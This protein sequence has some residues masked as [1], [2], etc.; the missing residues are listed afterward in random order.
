MAEW[1]VARPTGRCANCGR[2]LA[3]GEVFHAVLVERA[4]ALERLDYDA[5][6]WGGPPADA[7]CFWRSRVPERRQKQKVVMDNETL[8][9]L[10]RR[11]HP[12]KSDIQKQFR[13]VL[14]LWLMRKKLLRFEQT[15]REGGQEIWQMRLTADDSPQRVERV[16]LEDAELER[17][18]QQLRLLL[19]GQPTE[20]AAADQTLAVSGSDEEG[21]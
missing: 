13:F 5:E 21:R 2:L 7:F 1:Q 11:L 10:F 6:H 8:T 15:L 12:A 17:A 14:A 18:S 16:A 20:L 9:Q 19:E 3:E 4:G